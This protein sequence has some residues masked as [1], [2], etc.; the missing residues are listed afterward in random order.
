[1]EELNIWPDM[2]VEYR[3]TKATTS[4]T[5]PTQTQAIV[6]YPPKYEEGDAQQSNSIQM[7]NSKEGS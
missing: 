1:M 6:I 4:Q 3:H 2:G 7:T 5:V